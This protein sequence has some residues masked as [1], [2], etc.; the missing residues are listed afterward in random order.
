[1]PVTKRN[2][3]ATKILELKKG[4]KKDV[5]VQKSLETVQTGNGSIIGGNGTS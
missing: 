2:A 4:A 1:V 5:N 3:G